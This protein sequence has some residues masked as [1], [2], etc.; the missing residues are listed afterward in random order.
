MQGDLQI[1]LGKCWGAPYW[2]YHQ[3]TR[4][5]LSIESLY[6]FLSS[7]KKKM[8]EGCSLSEAAPNLGKRVETN[9]Q[10]HSGNDEGI[11]TFSAL[12]N[13]SEPRKGKS[14]YYKN[15][16][17]LKTRSCKGIFSLFYSRLLVNFFLKQCFQTAIL[18]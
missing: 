11:L 8:G 5:L 12:P 3:K 2:N 1:Y 16:G 9:V 18:K 15:Y 13:V 17:Q 6:F 14:M 10:N 4:K 7:K